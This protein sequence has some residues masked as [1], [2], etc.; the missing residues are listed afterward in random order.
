MQKGVPS[1]GSLLDTTR[2]TPR[3]RTRAMTEFLEAQSMPMRFECTR[4][5]GHMQNWSATWDLDSLKVLQAQGA[6]IRWMRG[7]HEVDATPDAAYFVISYFGRGVTTGTRGFDEEEFTRR[8]GEILLYDLT[9]PYGMDL[10]DGYNAFGLLISHTQLDLPVAVIR[11]AVR[12]PRDSPVHRHVARICAAVPSLQDNP[13]AESLAE[14]TVDLTRTLI[15]TAGGTP[16]D[17]ADAPAVTLPLR[18]ERY[19]LEHL[20]ETSLSA[21]RIAATHYVSVR[22]LYYV[23]S[24]HHDESLAEWIMFQRLDRASHA[25]ARGEDTITSVAHLYGF[26]DA[27]HFSRRFRERYGVTPRDWRAL[28]QQTTACPPA[29]PEPGPRQ[30]YAFSATSRG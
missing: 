14:V 21:A 20:R 27:A 22:Q 17:A 25:L 2:M 26:A 29:D 5:V 6:A 24:A 7:P 8:A 4:S 3:R 12:N 9:E 13:A 10:P 28:W 1:R 19:V 18:V 15:A 11:R 16:A 23:W 30:S